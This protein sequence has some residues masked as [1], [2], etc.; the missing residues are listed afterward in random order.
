MPAIVVPIYQ[1]CLIIPVIT[2]DRS[3]HSVV[4]ADVY[5]KSYMVQYLVSNQRAV[6]VLESRIRSVW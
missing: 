2:C 4:A 1:V 5:I 3:D 6:N